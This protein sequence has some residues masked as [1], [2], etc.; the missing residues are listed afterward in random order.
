MRERKNQSTN[1]AFDTRQK[2]TKQ[3]PI[4]FLQI[5]VHCHAKNNSTFTTHAV[6]R[7]S[8]VDVYP[9]AGVVKTKVT[10]NEQT[11]T[12]T[13][14]ISTIL[15]EEIIGNVYTRVLTQIQPGFTSSVNA[16]QPRL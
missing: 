15:G 10:A 5:S 2:K 4:I 7:S 8:H 3:D 9:H 13:L 14:G 1:P 6:D 11:S 12:G 16:P